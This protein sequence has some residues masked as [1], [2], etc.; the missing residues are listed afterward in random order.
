[1]LSIS[2]LF[3][4]FMLYSFIGWVYESIFC[5]ICEKKLV[6]RGFLNGPYCP[7]Y[8]AGA[9]LVIAVLGKIT[10]PVL[11]FF[12]SMLLT[13]VVE[14]FTSWVMERI[15]N[16]RW[17][18]YSDWKFNINGRVC[19][20]GLLAFGTMSLLLKF[21][22]HPFVLKLTERLP[23]VLIYILSSILLIT[24]FIDII[25]TVIGLKGFNKKLKEFNEYLNN[26]ITQSFGGAVNQVLDSGAY[27]QLKSVF[28]ALKDKLN[29]QESRILK[30]FPKFKSNSYNDI[31]EKL[32]NRKRK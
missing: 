17:W 7:I 28:G 14:Y 32:K 19:A 5:S 24:F 18:D 27:Q 16:A 13:G 15:F 26:T 29:R 25:L 22:I 11:L 30:S 9:I 2:K 3:I 12:L 23:N 20:L 31:V 21:I 4:W 10:N 8:G 1:M 6:N